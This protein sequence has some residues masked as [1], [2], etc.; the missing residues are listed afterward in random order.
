MKVYKKNI[1]GVGVNIESDIINSI[2]KVLQKIYEFKLWREWKDKIYTDTK[3]SSEFIE[4]ALKNLPNRSFIVFT[5]GT[6]DEIFVQFMK[7]GGKIYLDIP[8]WITNKFYDSKKVILE[9]LKKSGIKSSS[10]SGVNEGKDK[11]GIIVCFG[12]HNIKA[13]EVAVLICKEIYGINEPCVF[14]YVTDCLIPVHEKDQT[15]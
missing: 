4:Y 2:F 8:M 5:F 13:T 1:F 12:I 7:S 11:T 15:W 9:L 10:V 6:K 3:L 14:K